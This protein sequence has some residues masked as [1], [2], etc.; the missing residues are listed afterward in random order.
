M[1]VIL[2]ITI[3]DNVQLGNGVKRG[4][5]HRNPLTIIRTATG[6]PHQ[7]RMKMHRVRTKL[8]T[9]LSG[10]P[11]HH[12]MRSDGRHQRKRRWPTSIAMDRCA[13]EAADGF[14]PSIDYRGAPMARQDHQQNAHTLGR[15]GCRP[16]KGGGSQQDLL[17]GSRGTT[18]G[19]FHAHGLQDCPRFSDAG[20]ARCLQARLKANKGG[21]DP[22][23]AGW[24]MWVRKSENLQLVDQPV[25][26][27]FRMRHGG[28]E[29]YLAHER[30]GRMGRPYQ[31]NLHIGKLGVS[32][33]LG[34]AFTHG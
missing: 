19:G 34:P 3:S 26:N 9:S 1:A 20:Q 13:G 11:D 16:R 7:L 17:C 30:R 21:L 22:R 4:P 33:L 5:K 27:F 14:L 8:T 31:K 23:K 6:G 15:G 12:T 28:I 18:N 32:S 24:R 25:K 10:H 29:D 2:R